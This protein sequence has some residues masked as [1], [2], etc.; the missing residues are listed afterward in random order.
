[1]AHRSISSWA[2][3]ATQAPIRDFTAFGAVQSG[4]HDVWAHQNLLIAQHVGHRGQFGHRVRHAHEFRVAAIDRIAELPSPS[5][6]PS[7]SRSGAILRMY[8]AKRCVAVTTGCDRPDDHPVAFLKP[9]NDGP[10]LLDHAHRFMSESEALTDRV[11]AFKDVNIGSADRCRGHAQ[12]CV[13]GTDIGHRLFVE[14]DTDCRQRAQRGITPGTCLRESYTW[15]QCA[16]S[17]GSV[18]C[19]AM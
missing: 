14:N 11:F 6:F 8:A 10:E 9:F 3:T 2:K 1:V 19:L 5:R 17:V 4:R 12:Q 18:I 16:N 7:V 15:D 13:Q